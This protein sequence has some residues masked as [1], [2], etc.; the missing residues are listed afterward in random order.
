MDRLIANGLQAG[1]PWP[2]GAHFDGHGVN[3]AVFST[4]AQ[5]MELCLFD[6]DGQQELARLPLPCH[7]VDVWHGYL[8]GAQPGLVYGLRAHGPWWPDKGHR[9]DAS[10]LLL[11]PYAREIVG[12]F[13]WRE[14][15]FSPDRHYPG[16]KLSRDNAALALKSRVTHD[17]FDWGD[18][19]AP[20][21]TLTDTVLYECHVKGFSKLNPQ[22]PPELRGSYAGLAHPASISHLK[23]LGVTAVSLLPVQYSIS[24]ERLVNQGLSNYWGYNTIGFFCV[25]P[26]LAS[27]LDGKAARDE[28]RTMVRAL[29][30]AGLE[31]ILDVVYNH[32]AE[33]DESGPTISF[34]GL[35]NAS[36]YRLL[37]ND[38]SHYENYSGCGNTLNLRQPKVLQMVM[39][40]L[41]Y[42]VEDMHVDG[43]RFDLAPVLGRTD[44]GF[45]AQAA[46][47][48]AMAQDPVLSRVK[49]IAEPWDTGPGGYQVGG[50]PR[51]W[52]E[53]NDKFRD[54]TRRFWI[55]GAAAGDEMP[56]GCTRG[57][58][59]M[60]LC[61]SSDLYQ[62]RRRAPAKSVNYVVSH[63][64]FTLHDLVSYNQRHNEANGEDNRDGHHDNLS[65]NCGV[66]G[67]SDDP[68]VTVLRA[69]LQRVLLANTLLAQGT[70]MLCA[71]DEFGHTQDGNNNPYCQDNAT[72]WIDWSAPDTDLLAFTQHLVALRHQLQPFA[73]KWYSG[74]ADANGLYDVSW[75]NTDGSVLQHEAWHHATGRTLACLIGKPGRSATPLLLLFNAGA[76]REAFVLPPG[77]W[78]AL[79]DTSQ[80]RGQS[81]A[82]GVGGMNLPVAAH[83]M[84]LLQQISTP[85]TP[86][87]PP[88]P[89]PSAASHPG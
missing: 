77:Q 82:Q 35:D 18:D 44:T 1:H 67:P 83:G 55:Q 2:M 59:A 89:T 43:F 73:N 27:S 88:H 76:M 50:F 14:E 70:P 40:S 7:T 37:A 68:M 72:T 12:H 79:L 36:Y 56:S 29:H 85:S 31:V 87:R 32:T 20:G 33:A 51:G 30:A 63:D 24:E 9:F 23:G 17:Q 54:C 84:M 19:N 81:N 52:L 45:S 28:F 11:D 80:P 15:H 64:G 61:G 8:P 16:H 69:R 41:R 38:P 49:M 65:F 42:W 60:R 75:W 58:F 22:L 25:N 62:E 10:K 53:W 21:I 71:G 5:A 34:R 86:A 74:V 39:D 46:F 47:F 48:V 57:N 3:F 26:Q 13:N 78:Q 66:E 4:H 6:T